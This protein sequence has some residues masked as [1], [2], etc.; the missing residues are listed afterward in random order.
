MAAERQRGQRADAVRNRERLLRVAV[1]AF[2]HDDGEVTMESV[3]KRAGV[4]I[5]TLYRHFPTRDALVAAAYRH[6][7]QRVCEA[8]DALLA[9]RPADVA[10]RQ[11]MDRFVDYVA[12]KKGMKS[13]LQGVVDA[14]SSFFA[15]TFG[16]IV[17]ALD[18]L[19][20][21]GVALGTIRADVDAQ[22]V[23]RAMRA[24]WLTTDGPNGA[25]HA[26]RLLD[27]LMDGLRYG[28]ARS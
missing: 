3:A 16:Q 24:A 26:G 7:V 23:L 10:L 28:A 21:A 25:D 5:G 4:G 13:A 14:D 6:E 9:E 17:G 15:E 20:R 19:L 1:E 18:A 8:A 22:D 12:A 2:A 11:W 27:L